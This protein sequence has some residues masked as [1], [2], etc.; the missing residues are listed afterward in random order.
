MDWGISALGDKIV[1]LTNTW[2]QTHVTEAMEHS[3]WDTLGAVI[4]WD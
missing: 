4:R 1:N 2:I 3:C